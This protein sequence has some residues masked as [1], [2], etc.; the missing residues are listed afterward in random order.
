MTVIN[1]QYAGVLES[2][3]KTFKGSKPVMRKLE[4]VRLRGRKRSMVG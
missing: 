3:V 2:Y 1:R 4:V